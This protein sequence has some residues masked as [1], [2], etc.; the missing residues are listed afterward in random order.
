M[1]S[2]F[3]FW[4]RAVSEIMWK[5]TVEPDGP[6]MTI[7]SMH[8]SCW[9]AKAT[10]IHSE[11]VILIAFPLQQWLYESASLLRHTYIVVFYAESYRF[12]VVTEGIYNIKFDHKESLLQNLW[13]KTF[14]FI[15]FP[16]LSSV[17]WV[18][19]LFDHYQT[20][21]CLCKWGMRKHISWIS[22]SFMQDFFCQTSIS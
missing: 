19:K 20:S 11:Y 18:V 16:I 10:N 6:E 12:C 21:V 15:P 1:F 3:F 9:I 5:N 2:N 4:N 22:V 14:Y 13:Y 17:I 7:W 8:I